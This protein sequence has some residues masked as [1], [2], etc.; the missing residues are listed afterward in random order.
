MTASGFIEAAYGYDDD[1]PLDDKVSIVGATTNATYYRQVTAPVGERHNGKVD[2]SVT[3]VG[4]T[5]DPSTT[6]AVVTIGETQSRVSWLRVRG[7]GNTGSSGVSGIAI[8][9]TSVVGFISNC[10]VH[11]GTTTNSASTIIGITNGN[12]NANSIISNC[13]VANL[14]STGLADN[15]RS[16]GIN[17]GRGKVYNSTV[18]NVTSTNGLANG[19]QGDYSTSQGTVINSVSVGNGTNPFYTVNGWV[20]GTGWNACDLASVACTDQDNSNEMPSLDKDDLFT[21]LTANAEDLHLASTTANSILIDSGSDI[22]ALL[23]CTAG[24]TCY[25]IDLDVVPYNQPC[26]FWCWNQNNPNT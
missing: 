8:T 3:P 14:A 4:F 26:S 25:D 20:A 11:N 2:N 17:A 16:I 7:F 23:S 18:Y 22:S 19:I 5:L 10:L 6:G 13:L 1:G 12:A 15:I 24:S 9:G 21:D